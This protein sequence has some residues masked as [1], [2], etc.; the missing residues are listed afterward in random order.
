MRI[1]LVSYTYTPQVNGVTTVVDR[2]ARVLREFGHAVVVVAPRYP[3]DG[4]RPADE[5][6]IPSAA[7]P[8]YPAIRLSVPQFGTVSRYL[9]A[10]E[11][12]VVHVAT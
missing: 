12:Q 5:L 2:I 3:N 1:A 9:D 10:F 7:F 11:P 4:A 6:R 8:P